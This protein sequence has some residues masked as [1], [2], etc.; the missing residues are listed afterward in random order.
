M[1]MHLFKNRADMGG[2]AAAHSA[3]LINQAIHTAGEANIVLATGTSQFEMLG[4]LI[5]RDV[6]WS[7]VTAF[8]LDEY[9]GLP[10]SHQASFR[11]YLMKRFVDKVPDL[12]SFIAI[13]GERKDPA[14][15][16]RRLNTIIGKL[17]IDVA[18]VGIGENGHLAFNDPPADMDT[19]EPFI[20]VELDEYCRAQ[21]VGE[22]WFPSI[23]DVPNRAISMSIRQIMKARS[24][25]CTV[26]D[27]RKAQALK[28]AV[29]GSVTSMV[30]ASILQRHGDCHIFAD[31]A[32]GSHLS[33]VT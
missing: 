7:R 5:A 24:I 12:Y 26:P 21:Q 31:R 11:N 1:E 30:P 4:A 19:D 8:H 3:R 17:R 32:A 14:E 29:E 15:E 23:A 25:V 22:G 2:A 9:I 6:D 28:N 33:N 13:N 16:C 18:C 10:A 27:L 20:T